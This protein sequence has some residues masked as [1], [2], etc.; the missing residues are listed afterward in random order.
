MSHT[1]EQTA[2]GT[3]HFLTIKKKAATHDACRSTEAVYGQMAI[4]RSTF[5]FDVAKPLKKGALLKQ[6]AVNKSFKT[7][8]FVL[9]PGFLVY[10]DSDSKW[11]LDLL[12][13]ET[14]GVRG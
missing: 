4:R 1:R 11:R 14:L 13:G 6:G 7:R 3:A 5:A 2:L 9:Y 8:E 10:Y 12:K